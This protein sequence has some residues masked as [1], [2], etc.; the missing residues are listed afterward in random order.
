MLPDPSTLTEAEILD[1]TFILD[2]TDI[3][4]RFKCISE[5]HT[6]EKQQNGA[7]GFFVGREYEINADNLFKLDIQN[8]VTKFPQ[9]FYSQKYKLSGSKGKEVK[10]DF[11]LVF[12]T[13]GERSISTLATNRKRSS[14]Q[15]DFVVFDLMYYDRNNGKGN[16]TSLR[17]KEDIWRD[18]ENILLEILEAYQD[19]DKTKL[20]NLCFAGEYLG[21]PEDV[22]TWTGSEL[23]KAEALIKRTLISNN[24]SCSIVSSLMPFEYKHNK[25]LAGVHTVVNTEIFTG[26]ID[27]EFKQIIC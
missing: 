13:P 25:R 22:T 2:R 3:Y 23:S 18:T 26:C 8:F 4:R 27:G 17:E 24:F 16:N 14:Y 10:A 7:K 12:M 21:L 19:N 9:Y 1:T 20:Y 5:L 6:G 15:F 11:P